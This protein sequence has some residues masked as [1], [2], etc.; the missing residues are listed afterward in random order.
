MA[1]QR[2]SKVILLLL[3]LIPTLLGAG[4]EN[5]AEPVLLV[6]NVRSRFS[7]TGR[8]VYVEGM[9]ENISNKPL[10]GIECVVMIVDVQGTLVTSNDAFTTI[11]P[12]APGKNSPFRVMLDNIWEGKYYKV[13]FQ[14]FLHGAVRGSQKA[15]SRQ[16]LCRL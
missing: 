5:E 2:Y 1:R 10:Q 6:H 4:Q 7:E 8:F 3:T 12:L 15:N 11:N 9:V 14:Q 16:I 13:D